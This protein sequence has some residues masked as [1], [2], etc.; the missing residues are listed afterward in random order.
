MRTSGC[1]RYLLS[2]SAGAALLAG[3]GG[4]QPPSGAPGAMPQTRGVAVSAPCTASNSTSGA[5][6]RRATPRGSPSFH[7]PGDVRGAA[8]RSHTFDFTGAEQSFKVPSGVRSINVVADGAAGASERFGLGGRTEATIPVTPHETLYVFVGGQG[9]TTGGGFNGGGG[10]PGA[11]GYGGGGASDVRAGG[12]GLSNRIL[13][14]GAGGGPG[15]AGQGGRGAPVVLGGAGGGP[16]GEHGAGEKGGKGRRGGG[17][18]GGSQSQGGSGGT[19]GYYSG[20]PGSSGALGSGGTGGQNGSYS[21]ESY[22]NGGGGG[23][24]YYGGGGGG[25][26]GSLSCGPAVDG[27]G[28]GGGSSYVESSATGVEMYQGW[29]DDT[30]NGL[31]VFSWSR[32]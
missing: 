16:T 24:G 26:G 31:V 8:S 22:G 29:K 14:A 6:P 11:G 21:S 12:D 2:V 3:C 23:G 5:V 10:V 30:G 28:G 18:G 19:G 25:G 13:V 17:G 7:R 32:K 15:A 1:S 20:Y 27:G 9:S 4:P